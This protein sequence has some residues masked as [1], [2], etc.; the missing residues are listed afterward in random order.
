MNEITIG[1]PRRPAIG[2]I[3]ISTLAIN[4]FGK[5]GRNTEKERMLFSRRGLNI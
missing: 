1:A 2:T 3:L 4:I 5:A